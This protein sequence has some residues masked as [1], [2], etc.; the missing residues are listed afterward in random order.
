MIELSGEPS[1]GSPFFDEK[2]IELACETKY[3][4]YKII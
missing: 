2:N 4:Y 3:F 1:S